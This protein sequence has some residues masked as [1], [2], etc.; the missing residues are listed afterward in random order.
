[1]K[2]GVKLREGCLH[3]RSSSKMIRIY[4]KDGD[5]YTYFTKRNAI[6]LATKLSEYVSVVYFLDYTVE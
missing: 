2:N 4:N 6:K 1:M 5:N 3:L